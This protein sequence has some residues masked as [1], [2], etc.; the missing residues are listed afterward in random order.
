MELSGRQRDGYLTSQRQFNDRAL[1][2]GYP[3]PCIIL[4]LRKQ[5]GNAK[6][7]IEVERSEGTI[8]H[9]VK[10]CG[11]ALG[12]HI[13]SSK[14]LWSPLLS[15]QLQSQADNLFCFITKINFWMNLYSVFLFHTHLP[16]P[17]TGSPIPPSHSHPW[18]SYL[19][20]FL[21]SNP[22]SWQ[23][24]HLLRWTAFHLPSP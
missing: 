22:F 3:F 24:S 23:N 20:T 7:V 2:E 13:T 1:V 6:T 14:L 10:I 9:W 18:L 5:P 15:S 12:S 19:I 4:Y 16:T 11:L 8:A 21:N 17:F